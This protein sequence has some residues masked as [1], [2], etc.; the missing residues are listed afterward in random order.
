MTDAS[1]FHRPEVTNPHFHSVQTAQQRR[2]TAA[3]RLTD[4]E[5]LAALRDMPSQRAYRLAQAGLSEA[6]ARSMK[7]AHLRPVVA[8]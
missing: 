8:E 3:M 2:I 7:E 5:I 6:L 4:D 1:G